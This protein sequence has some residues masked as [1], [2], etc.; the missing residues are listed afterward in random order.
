VFERLDPAARRVFDLAQYEAQALQHNYIGTEHLLAALALDGGSAADLLATVGCD[1]DVIRGEIVSVIG[2]GLPRRGDPDTLL[3][4]LGID[5]GEVRR[6]VEST[7][8]TGAVH[9]AAL[10]VRPRQSRRWPGSRW[11]PGCQQGRPCE[12][13]L[14][15]TRWFGFAPRLKRVVDL[16]VADAAPRAASPLHLLVATI[17]E[18]EGVACQILAGLG[19]DTPAL[20]SAARGELG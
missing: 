20:A 6:R 9:R 7:F 18:G 8:G 11:W 1:P 16:A 10:R 3:A 19:V 5:V 17:D 2:R 15:G 14:L 13:A 12:S 4:T